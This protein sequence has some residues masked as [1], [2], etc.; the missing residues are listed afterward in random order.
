MTPPYVMLPGFDC[1]FEL[2]PVPGAEIG[3]LPAANPPAAVDGGPVS[4]H[5]E[6]KR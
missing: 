5:P 3:P 1:H 6:G 4:V 2:L